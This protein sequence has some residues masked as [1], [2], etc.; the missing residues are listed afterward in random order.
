MDGGGIFSLHIGSD[1]KCV[2]RL[3]R[4]LDECCVIQ[5]QCD[6]PFLGLEGHFFKLVLEQLQETS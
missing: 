1:A 6:D 3:P 4:L 2:V 5:K